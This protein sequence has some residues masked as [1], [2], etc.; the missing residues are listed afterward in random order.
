M[1]DAG[2]VAVWHTPAWPGVQ[3]RESRTSSNLRTGHGKLRRTPSHSVL[4]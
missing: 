3:R 2:C 4:G 1:P